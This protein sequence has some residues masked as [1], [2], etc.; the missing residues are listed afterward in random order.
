MACTLALV[1]TSYY[2]PRIQ[3]DIE[4]YVKTCLV[5]QQDKVEQQHP[6]R[7]LKPLPIAERPWESV[8]IDFIVALPKSEWCGRIMVV[9][10]RFSKY[11]TFI[12]TKVD[13]AARLFFMH[14]VKLWGVP[15][16][17]VSDKDPCFTG[18]F[19]RELLV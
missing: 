10:D 9:V 4:A 15:R 19:W 7:L 16:S 5:C 14:V 11:A 2:W 17:I 18:K 12:P 8:S 6:A 1:Q 13:K 3:D